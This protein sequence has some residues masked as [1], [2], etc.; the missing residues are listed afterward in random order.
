MPEASFAM[1]RPIISVV[2]PTIA[3]REHWLE[4]AVESIDETTSAFGYE[5]LVY[6]DLP[7]CGAG[8]NIGIME[9]KGDYILLFADDLEARH[10]WCEA[11]IESLSRN[12]IPCPRILN[13]DGSLQSCGDYAKEDPDGTPT[14]LARVPFLTRHMA[15]T[16]HP[17]FENHY[18]GDHWITWKAKQFGWPTLVVRAME[19]THHFAM[20]GRIDTLASDVEAYHRATG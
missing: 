20:E 8:W 15:Q 5:L 13:S 19:F 16:L 4:R 2:I 3:G 12:V 9:A 6:R 14:V 11:G 1:A 7:T 10:G 18:M 17:I